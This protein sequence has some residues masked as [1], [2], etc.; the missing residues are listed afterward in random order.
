[1]GRKDVP[2]VRGGE[3]GRRRKRRRRREVLPRVVEFAYEAEDSPLA[4]SDVGGGAFHCHHLEGEG[5]WVGGWVGR[6]IDEPF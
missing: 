5:G 3:R 1:M 6:D 4:G 2:G